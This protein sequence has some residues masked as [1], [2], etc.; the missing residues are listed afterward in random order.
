MLT[1]KRNVISCQI[2]VKNAK[3]LWPKQTKYVTFWACIVTERPSAG[4]QE[5]NSRS[6]GLSGWRSGA[7]V[8]RRTSDREVTGSIPVGRSCV[9]TLGKLFTTAWLDA[10]S[11]RYYME[12]LNW[13]PLPFAYVLSGYYIR[14]VNRLKLADIVTRDSICYSAYML[15]QFRLSVRPSQISR[16][17][18]LSIN[19]SK[20]VPDTTKVTIDH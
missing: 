17:L 18:P 9:T 12:S 10:D 19:I 15:W 20:T 3:S 1:V 7:T 14:Q 13:V 11:L 2:A 5:H 8:G 16:F 6:Y 4:V